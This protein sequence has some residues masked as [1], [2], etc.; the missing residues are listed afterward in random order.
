MHM[1][2]EFISVFLSDCIN[3]QYQVDID[4]NFLQGTKHT[5]IINAVDLRKRMKYGIAHET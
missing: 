1:V 5:A 2:C 3:D 4:I